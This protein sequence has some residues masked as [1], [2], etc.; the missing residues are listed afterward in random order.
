MCCW[1]KWAALGKSEFF[2]TIPVLTRLMG[3]MLRYTPLLLLAWVLG[4]QTTIPD[5]PA[6]HA[7]SAWLE[8]FNSGDRAKVQAYL[9]K[10]EPESDDRTDG[11]LEFRERS[12]GFEVVRVE[13][14][15]PLH[16]DVLLK[17][18]GSANQALAKIGVKD[19]DPVEVLSIGIRLVGGREGGPV[20]PRLSL[21]GAVRAL[22]TEAEGAAAK[23]SF[24]GA[25]LVAKN[26]KVLF[27]QAYG[28]ADRQAQIKNTL[29]TRFRL[30]SMNKMFTATAAL[31]LVGSGKLDLAA[32]IG[33]YLPD[34]PNK[35]VAAKVTVRHLLT[36][37]GGTGDIFTDEYEKRRLEIRE[38]GDY[39]KLLG[40]RGPE[41]E[42]GSR[43]EYSNY[44]FVL[45][46]YL[47]ERVSGE[48]Y[49]EYVRKH[50]F[51][52]AG[53]SSTDSLP[54]SE[55][56]GERS[57]GY[58]RRDGK[59]LSNADTLPW[60]GSP[61]GGGYSTVGDLLRFAEALSAGKLISKDLLTAMT[62]KQAG[63][64]EEGARGYGFGMG[65]LNGPGYKG[66][67]HSGGAPGMNGDLRVFP[68]TGVVVIVLANLDPPAASKLAEGF[69]ASM[70]VD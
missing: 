19:S 62:T 64:E 56:V 43:W 67:G 5:T 69:Q 33:K 51:E 3:T 48:S 26:G 1:T 60:R 8:A 20:A 44:G 37:T 53:M 24:S 52:P 13:K 36:H 38:P 12:G 28:M 46:G 45:L 65:I 23:D 54:E 11:M 4:A 70:P 25:V 57:K 6:G 21:D 14:S 34:Y 59:W 55:K 18:R 10:H 16:I 42:P 35:Q 47:V 61:A 31:Q 29:K 49:Y 66:F 41:F 58:R 40:G 17:E 32:P 9:K 2:A 27:E 68:G 22:Q 63:P 15:E 7:F 30:G 50:V 39:V